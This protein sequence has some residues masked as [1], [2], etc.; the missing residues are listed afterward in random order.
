MKRTVLTM[1]ALL[2]AVVQMNAQF[3]AQP[4]PDRKQKW[5][6]AASSSDL[7]FMI[8]LQVPLGH[9]DA[10]SGTMYQVS[11]GKFS[12]SS[13]F[14]LRAGLEFMPEYMD[15]KGSIGFPVALA[16]RSPL[17]NATLIDAG[18][19]AA[20]GAIYDGIYGTGPTFGSVFLD[21]LYGFISRGEFTLGLTPGYITGK[22]TR[23]G[24]SD[25][26][27]TRYEGVSV[28]N[29]FFTTVDLN[30]TMMWRIGHVNICAAP[31][32]HYFLTDNYREYTEYSE[33]GAYYIESEPVGWRLSLAVGLSFAF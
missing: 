31:G 8:G 2:L 20:G 15:V 10:S 28:K 9:N 12:V 7:R 1:A 13:G 30:Y 5:N 21:F 3:V 33:G 18:L 32:I 29:K 6:P 16:Y 22:A 17:Y 25:S 11:Y 24:I 19:N 27:G 26:Y 14:G 23:A 4:L